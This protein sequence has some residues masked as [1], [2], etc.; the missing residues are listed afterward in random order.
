MKTLPKARQE[1]IIVRELPDEVLIYD[2]HRDQAHCLNKTAG[3]VW[4][5]CDGRT[6]VA[7]VARLLSAKGQTPVDE[8]VVLLALDQLAE[9]HLLIEPLTQPFGARVSRRKL[10]L[11]YAP[12]ALALPVVLS[13]TAPTAAAA[14]TPTPTPVPTPDCTAV[15]A[16]QGCPCSSDGDCDTSNCNGGVCG[17]Q[18]RP[19]PEN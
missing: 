11:K 10:V 14:A 5:H 12:A 17:P 15:P 8:S 2:R 7:T 18:L 13:I 9:R 16:P 19:R 4:Q 6:K 1:G 3:F